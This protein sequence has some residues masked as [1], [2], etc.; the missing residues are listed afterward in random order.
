[1]DPT[2]NTVDWSKV[3]LTTAGVVGGWLAPRVYR[4]VR[5][6]GKTEQKLAEDELEDALKRAE[7]AHANADPT[8]DAA[9]DAAVV[10]AKA[11]RAKA[12]RLGALADAFADPTEPP[13]PIKP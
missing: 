13:D 9:A 4:A 8:D 12:A 5:N 11:L 6:L 7:A 1:M 10:R 2:L 3:L